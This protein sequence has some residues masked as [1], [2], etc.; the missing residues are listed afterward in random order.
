MASKKKVALEEGARVYFKPT[1][2][3][4]MI[5]TVTTA[6]GHRDLNELRK[7]AS[8]GFIF[9]SGAGLDVPAL[10]A[11]FS[12]LFVTDDFSSVLDFVSEF[13]EKSAKA[14]VYVATLYGDGTVVAG[15]AAA[16]AEGVALLGEDD[17]VISDAGAV[18]YEVYIK[19]M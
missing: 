16:D 11:G 14:K 13:K 18:A 8:D 7:L 5:T 10:P 12:N 3:R 2:K 17:M 4:Y 9:Y 19:V 1:P 6:G 15:Y